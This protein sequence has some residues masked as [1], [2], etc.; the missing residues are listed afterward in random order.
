MSSCGPWVK[1][2]PVSRL[3]PQS[4]RAKTGTKGTSATHCCSDRIILSPAHPRNWP[5]NAPGPAEQPCLKWR[6]LFPF[7]PRE[8]KA[9]SKS[10]YLLTLIIPAQAGI[11]SSLSSLRRTLQRSLRPWVPAFAGS[12]HG[13]PSSCYALPEDKELD[14]IDRPGL[15]RKWLPIF[16]GISANRLGAWFETCPEGPR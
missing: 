2:S 10:A 12:K 1:I 13:M 5:S 3:A 14:A 16:P 15:V 7:V 11:Q 9:V 4:T 8:F 6:R